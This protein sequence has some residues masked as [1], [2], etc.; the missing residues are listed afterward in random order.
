MSHKAGSKRSAKPSATTRKSASEQ[1]SP[2]RPFSNS[3]GHATPRRQ[4]SSRLAARSLQEVLANDQVQFAAGVFRHQL[5]VSDDG[6]R[7]RRAAFAAS[8]GRHTL[9]GRRPHFAR[10]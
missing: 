6:M 5:A 3:G 9:H 2:N 8:H 4:L 1:S 10:F 7:Q